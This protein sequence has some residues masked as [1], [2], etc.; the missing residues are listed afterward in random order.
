MTEIL[1]ELHGV[2]AELVSGHLVSY[3][4]EGV[5]GPLVPGRGQP[6]EPGAGRGADPRPGARRLPRRSSCQTV[7][8]IFHR[9]SRRRCGSARRCATQTGMDQ[10]KL[11]VASVAVD[12]AHEVFD[13][14]ADKTVL[15][16]GAGKMGELTLQHLKGLSPGRILVTNRS[17]ERA[18]EAAAAL[19]RP[20]RAV[21]PAGPGAD[22]G[23]PGDQHDRRERAD[24]HARAIRPRAARGG[25]TG[26]P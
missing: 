8:P 4:D 13:A 19:G 6:G 18:A 3:H 2:E 14:F 26:C 1:V 7:G 9:S 22:R 12:V 24:R 20:R 25:G 5:V 21:R 10:G 23:R 16:I 15:V 17:A 11:S